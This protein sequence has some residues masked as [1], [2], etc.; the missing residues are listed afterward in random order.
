[1]ARKEV[2][3]ISVLS[4]THTGIHEPK[5][6]GDLTEFL[7]NQYFRF[8]YAFDETCSSDLVY[9]YT[10]KPLVQTV[11]DGGMRTCF[12]Y[13]QTGSGKTHAIGGVCQNRT[14][15]WKKRIFAMAVEDVCKFLKSPGY[16]VLKLMVSVS[17]FEI[18]GAMSS[19][20]WRIKP[21]CASLKMT[22]SKCR[23]LVLLKEQSTQWMR[24]LKAYSTVAVLEHP[25]RHQ[26][27]PVL[28]GLMQYSRL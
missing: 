10:A 8:D 13:G 7:E 22:S 6:K 26:E 17:F 27:T 11:F 9:K 5:L 4:K 18:C 28:H 25:G 1:L 21:N 19:I 3:V 24:S 16:K 14:Q 23:S 15:D 20:Y 2:D 12:A